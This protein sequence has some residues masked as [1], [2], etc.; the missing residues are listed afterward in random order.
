MR[1]DD[2]PPPAAR[3]A[4]TTATTAVP[5]A[6]AGGHRHH[7]PWEQPLLLH[8]PVTPV[9]AARGG[10]GGIDPVCVCPFVSRDASSP[11]VSRAAS[12]PTFSRLHHL[13]KAWSI[14]SDETTLERERSLRRRRYREEEDPFSTASLSPPF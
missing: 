8:R 3:Q 6:S 2:E 1:K 9:P 14:A 4:D 12:R 10:A 11:F 5:T 7:D 13:E